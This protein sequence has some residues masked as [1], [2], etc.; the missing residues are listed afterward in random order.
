MLL[1][2]PDD[3]KVI[4]LARFAADHGYEIQR[5]SQKYLCEQT[6]V[7]VPMKMVLQ[8]IPPKTTYEIHDG[9][10]DVWK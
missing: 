7:M 9:H 2:I 8:D 4:D 6:L 5:M 3:M 10:A 1:R